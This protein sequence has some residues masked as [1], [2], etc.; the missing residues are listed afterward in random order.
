MA[1]SD[2]E[3]E[4]K[5]NYICSEIEFKGY[6]LRKVLLQDET[7]DAVTFYKWLDKDEDKIKRYVRATKGR[8]DIVFEEILDIADDK[9]EDIIYSNEGKE[10]FNKEFAARSRIKIDARK[11]MI[12]KMHPKK[13]A[14]SMKLDLDITQIKPITIIDYKE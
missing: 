3:I 1:Y 10:I 13:Y 11:W 7:P 4:T 5:F 6:S 2:K 14:D 8:A 9:S 12:G